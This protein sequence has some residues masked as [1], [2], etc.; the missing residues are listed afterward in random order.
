MLALMACRHLGGS[1]YE[2]QA[3]MVDSV[4]GITMYATCARMTG[5]LACHQR[6]HVDVM[7]KLAS[8]IIKW[9]LWHNVIDTAT[10]VYTGRAKKVTPRKNFISPKL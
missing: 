7:Y 6:F 1:S 2:I 5:A 3:L 4:M 10:I 9:Q 8:A